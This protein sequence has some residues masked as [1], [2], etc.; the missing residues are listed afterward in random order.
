MGFYVN[1]AY[2]ILVCNSSHVTMELGLLLF[3]FQ[4]VCIGFQNLC[5]K[6]F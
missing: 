6:L 3:V 2:P 5:N 4:P 1:I